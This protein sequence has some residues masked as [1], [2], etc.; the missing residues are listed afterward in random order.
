MTTEQ[1]R[2]VKCWP[3]LYSV[4]PGLG[5]VKNVPRERVALTPEAESPG[6]RATPAVPAEHPL[7]QFNRQPKW[8]EVVKPGHLDPEQSYFIV[9]VRLGEWRVY[10]REASGR[11]IWALKPSLGLRFKGSDQLR[12][13]LAKI[14]MAE[15]STVLAV[16]VPRDA[17][18][19]W[20]QK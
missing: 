5:L 11:H 12:Q 17:A 1:T 18:Q 7:P 2:P 20:P 3:F 4:V 13:N 6:L 8:A 10:G 19:R 14:A 15:R 16:L 9:R